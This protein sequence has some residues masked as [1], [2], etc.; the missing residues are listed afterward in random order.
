MSKLRNLES[1]ENLK[2]KSI[3]RNIEKSHPSVQDTKK[4]EHLVISKIISKSQESH[5]M[6]DK[7][8]KLSDCK[9]ITYYRK[10]GLDSLTNNRNAI[11]RS[12]EQKG[13][14]NY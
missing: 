13:G 7:V 8:S 14:N 2:N 9:K 1:V 10:N 5:D 12:N 3:S 4:L 11:M 6:F